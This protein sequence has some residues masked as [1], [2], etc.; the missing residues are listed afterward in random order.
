MPAPFRPAERLA[1][2]ATGWN[3]AI[4]LRPISGAGP[5][6]AALLAGD[7]DLTEAPPVQEG[8]R[9]QPAQGLWQRGRAQLAIR[10]ASGGRPSLMLLEEQALGVSVNTFRWK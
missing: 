6:A 1:F 8:D 9:G 4:T 2:Q 7:V 3:G 5:R 10:M